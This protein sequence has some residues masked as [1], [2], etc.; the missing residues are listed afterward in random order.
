MLKMFLVTVLLVTSLRALA[1]TQTKADQTGKQDSPSMQAGEAIFVKKCFQCHSVLEGQ[2]PR[3]G[4]SLYREM[5]GRHPKQNA[6]TIRQ[7]LKNGKGKMPS[8]GATLTK[9]DT[10]NLIAYIRTL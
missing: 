2:T 1:G 3:L 6:S 8:F 10:D 9:E 4:P 7:L 5:S